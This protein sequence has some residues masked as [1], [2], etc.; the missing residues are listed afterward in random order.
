M[1]VLHLVQSSVRFKNGLVVLCPTADP[2]LFVLLNVALQTPTNR[3]H[4]RCMLRCLTIGIPCLTHCLLLYLSHSCT[5]NYN[6]YNQPWGPKMDKSLTC[7]THVSS[8]GGGHTSHH[9]CT[10]PCTCTPTHSSPHPLK[11]LVAIMEDQRSRKRCDMS[12]KVSQLTT[13]LSLSLLSQLKA[14]QAGSWYS[15]AHHNASLCARCS[16]YKT[17]VVCG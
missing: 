15:H 17:P 3:P 11:L 14:A 5:E 16:E 1:A 9:V 10:T 13:L 12:G 6:H 7:Q 8:S 4:Q 2:S